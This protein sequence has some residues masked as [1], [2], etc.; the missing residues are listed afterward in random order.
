MSQ[1]EN[2]SAFPQNEFSAY[3]ERFCGM[4]LRD[5]FA[6]QAL[7]GLMSHSVHDHCP[8]FGDGEPF[9]RDAYAVADAMLTERAK[10]V[11]APSSSS[12]LLEALEEA[13][14]ALMHYEWYANPK[15]GGASTE[16]L[17]VRGMVDAAIAK[18]KGGAA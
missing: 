2:P 14:R 12:G 15:S 13:H 7:V 17:T 16:N 6:S 9:A 4:A 1:P 18:A 8:L 5:W 10:S 11:D 3:T